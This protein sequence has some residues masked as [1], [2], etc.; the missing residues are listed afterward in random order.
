MATHTVASVGTRHYDELLK[1]LR[2]AR[3][4]TG[5]SQEALSAKLGRSRTYIG[6]IEAGTRRLDLVELYLVL[7]SLEVQPNEFT[8]DLLIAFDQLTTDGR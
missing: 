4:A 7:R 1:R 2:E 5:I 8:S 3:E 6:K